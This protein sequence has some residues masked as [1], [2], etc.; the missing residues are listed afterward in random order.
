M[1]TSTTTSTTTT[2]SPTTSV[3]DDNIDFGE[4]QGVYTAIII[5]KFNTHFNDTD[6][7]LPK[8]PLDI[9]FPSVA[10]GPAADAANDSMKFACEDGVA[11][12]LAYEGL[13][14][15]GEA[16]EDEILEDESYRSV[17]AGTMCETAVYRQWKGVEGVDGDDVCDDANGHS[18]KSIIVNV[19]V[20]V[21]LSNNLPMSVMTTCSDTTLRML[22]FVGTECAGLLGAVGYDD[23]LSSDGYCGGEVVSCPSN[24]PTFRPTPR[25]TQ[26]VGGGVAPADK[27]GDNSVGAAVWVLVALGIGMVLVGLV[28]FVKYWDRLFS[29]DTDQNEVSDGDVQE[30]PHEIEPLFDD[31][32]A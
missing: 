15:E 13:D 19:C 6:A 22:H 26:D 32:N 23:I 21:M 18:Q 24:S 27:S 5:D 31:E 29:A 11:H 17:C 30:E 28:L 9:C 2:S 20:E 14:C 7:F 16:V 10:L 1:T 25:P 8:A 4:C 12:S 3:S